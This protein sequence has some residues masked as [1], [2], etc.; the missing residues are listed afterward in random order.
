MSRRS[1]AVNKYFICALL[2]ANICLFLRQRMVCVCVGRALRRFGILDFSRV[3]SQALSPR[4]VFNAST[5]ALFVLKICLAMETPP[6]ACMWLCVVARHNDKRIR[7]ALR[8]LPLGIKLER[9]RSKCKTYSDLNK[10]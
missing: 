10:V 6:L 3:G 7:L 8:V 4:F 5:Q 2:I 9:W 1:R